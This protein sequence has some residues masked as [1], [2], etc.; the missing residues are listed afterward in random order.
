MDKR[1]GLETAIEWDWGID[2]GADNGSIG[3]TNHG[4]EAKVG[5][6]FG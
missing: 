5:Y 2:I 4:R 1:T 3:T 6:R